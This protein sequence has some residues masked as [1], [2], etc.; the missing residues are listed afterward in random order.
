MYPAA[1][2]R[3]DYTVTEVTRIVDERVGTLNGDGSRST[4]ESETFEAFFDRLLPRALRTTVRL[5]GTPAS[6][7]DAAVEAFAR[8]YANWERVSTLPH[9]DAWVL[10]VAANVACDQLRKATIESRRVDDLASP[11]NATDTVDLRVTFVPA[12][13]K[14][15]PRQR[16]VVVLTHVAGLP[17]KEVAELLGCSEESVK[18]HLRRALR[19]LR[20]D[21]G[22]EA[23]K[24]DNDDD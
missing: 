1:G 9:R 19:R 22:P 17:R 13:T 7:E 23:C 24:G 11:T 16:E 4:A 18:T 6:A 20:A 14:L 3:N 12:L 10:R 5:L 15:A 2:P 21:L 8:A